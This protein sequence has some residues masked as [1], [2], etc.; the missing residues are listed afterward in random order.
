[1]DDQGGRDVKNTK[2]WPKIKVEE[3]EWKYFDV[4]KHWQQL[5]NIMMD[6]VQVTCG[7]SKGPMQT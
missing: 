7:L 5:K 6:T 2:S 1:M 4:N 3:A